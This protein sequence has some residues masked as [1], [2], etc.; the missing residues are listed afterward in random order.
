MGWERPNWFADAGWGETPPHVY[1]YEHP[2]WFSAVGSE[3]LATRQAVALFDQTSFAK[4]VLEGPDSLAALNWLCA[5]HVDK[6]VG[7]LTYT[8]MFAR[9]I[10]LYG[11]AMSRVKA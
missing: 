11:P 8:R 6:P 1:T 3:H 9:L 10:L 2:N 4:L 7:C 5:N